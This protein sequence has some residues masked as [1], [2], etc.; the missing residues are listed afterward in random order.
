M[1]CDAK[2]NLL[3]NAKD[4]ASVAMYPLQWSVGRLPIYWEFI[5]DLFISK[6]DLIEENEGLKEKLLVAEGR[7]RIASAF[8]IE[9]T[10][11]RKFAALDIPRFTARV[12]EILPHNFGRSALDNWILIGKGK[13]D[14]IKEGSAVINESGLLGQVTEVYPLS[15]KVTLLTE[16]DFPI[17]VIIERTFKNVLLFGSGSNV[18]LRFVSPSTDIRE[19]DVLVTSGIDGVYPFGLRVARVSKALRE[20]GKKFMTIDVGLFAEHDHGRFVVVLERE[21]K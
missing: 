11:L 20:S 16:K 2:L 1:I 12:A 5:T 18:E 6:A 4:A 14:G 10:Q 3:T 21:R 13:V 9:N 15:S 19:G 7:L 17:S 8:E